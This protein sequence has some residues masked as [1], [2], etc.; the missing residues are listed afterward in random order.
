MNLK[1][2]W[3]RSRL[4]LNSMGEP[5]TKEEE[6]AKVDPLIQPVT[7]RKVTKDGLEIGGLDGQQVAWD[8]TRKKM[9]EQGQ[10]DE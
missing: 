6:K 9:I 7:D 2:L 8:S 1:R 10:D 3:E 4:Y 5:Q